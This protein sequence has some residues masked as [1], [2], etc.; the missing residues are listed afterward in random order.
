MIIK[1]IVA[2]V[3]CCGLMCWAICAIPKSKEEQLRDD[4]EQIEYLREYNKKKNQR[5]VDKH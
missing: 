3:I 4:Q 5:L 2:I 1:L